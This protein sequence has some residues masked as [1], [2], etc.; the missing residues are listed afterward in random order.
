MR[1]SRALQVAISETPAAARPPFSIS[2]RRSP[3]RDWR[4]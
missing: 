3:R 4:S 1:N 2:N